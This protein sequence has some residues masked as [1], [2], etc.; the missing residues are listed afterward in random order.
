MPAIAAV[1]T[2]T[3][4]KQLRRFL[5]A[6]DNTLQDKG[7]HLYKVQPLLDG[8]R[9]NCIRIEPEIEHSIDEQI[10]PAKTKYSGIRQYNPK[11][12]VKWGFKNFVRA[13]KSGIMYDFFIYTDALSA[14]E[15]CTGQY[16]VTRLCE[17]LPHNKNHKL[18]FDNWFSSLSL[19]L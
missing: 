19:C 7:N 16:V 4:Y 12:P 5:H 3:R 15:K 14:S 2:R 13:G 17:T 11:K 6:N 18:F 1:I 10:I 8:V 9:A